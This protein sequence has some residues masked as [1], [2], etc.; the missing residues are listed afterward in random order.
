[1]QKTTTTTKRENVK[2]FKK[3]RQMTYFDSYEM[4]Q[5]FFQSAAKA[6]AKV[7]SYINACLK[8]IMEHETS[9]NAQAN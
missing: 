5:Y 4:E 2:L 8:K 1:M 6:G 9:I 3:K 7:P